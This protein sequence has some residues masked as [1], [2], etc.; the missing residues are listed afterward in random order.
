[1]LEATI[2]YRHAEASWGSDPLE[3]FGG[4]SSLRPDTEAAFCSSLAQG[5]QACWSQSFVQR[6][7]H[8]PDAVEVSLSF[9][10]PNV[11][12]AQTQSVYGWSAL[13]YQAWARGQLVVNASTNQIVILYTDNVLEFRID[14]EKHFGGD[15]YAFRRAP[16]VLHLT[17]GP[18]QVDIRLLRDIRLMGGAN[19][20]VIP[21]EIR[22]QTTKATLSIGEGYILT[23]EVVSGILAAPYASVPVRNDSNRWLIVKGIHAVS[24]GGEQHCF[25]RSLSL[26]F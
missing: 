13:Q 7:H 18:H 10:F 25:H 17:P 15:F 5:G 14:N 6:Y 20:S 1:M 19:G 16:L 8:C 26:S 4:F 21:I 22:A 12:W 23:S 2:A 24:V 3:Y 11:N 9:S